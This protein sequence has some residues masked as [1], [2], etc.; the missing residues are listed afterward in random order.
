VRDRR[1]AIWMRRGRIAKRRANPTSLDV[2]RC[3]TAGGIAT[4][5]GSDPDCYF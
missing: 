2:A 1:A 3:R 4:A 5:V